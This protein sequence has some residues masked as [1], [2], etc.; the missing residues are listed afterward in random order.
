MESTHLTKAAEIG[1][2]AFGH[3]SLGEG[4]VEAIEAE[5]NQ[6]PDFRVFVSLTAGQ[7]APGDTERPQEHGDE[8]EEESAKQGKKTAEEGEAGARTDICQMRIDR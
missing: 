7:R 1:E 8:A 5:E 4:G 3:V 2:F 6:F